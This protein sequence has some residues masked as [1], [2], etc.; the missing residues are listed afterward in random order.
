[1]NF[2]EKY[3]KISLSHSAPYAYYGMRGGGFVQFR[4]SVIK[5]VVI[6]WLT[7]I[8]IVFVIFAVSL[9]RA[10]PI[11]ISYAQSHAKALMISAFDDA[12]TAALT[13]LDYKY[14]DMAVVSRTA[15]SLVSSIE[16]D[17]QKLNILRS[18]ISKKISEKCAENSENVLH[19][20]L[21]SL[22]GSEYTAGYGPELKFKLKFSQ[23][24]ILDFDSKFLSAG[25]NSIFH[26]IIIKANLSCGIIML[27]ADKSFS[28]N[29]TAIAAQ[30]VISGAVPN[31]FTNVIE[32]PA[33]DAADDIFN[34]ADK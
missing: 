32:T 24:P 18:E 8:S 15:D 20:S 7:V 34:Y 27:G 10:R 22:L 6:R 17:Y 19:I 4:K 12:V 26:Q 33:S 1:M 11:I 21:G 2:F 3:V 28:V 5:S 9:F 23:M 30:T 29:L 14:D 25:I 13:S 31:S 16:I